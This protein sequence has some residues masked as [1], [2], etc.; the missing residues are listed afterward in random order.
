MTVR[1]LIT[2]SFKS[3]HIIGAGDELD[4]EEMT[5]AF[6]ELNGIVEQANIDKL[7]G[8]FET[9]INFPTIA[10]Q[11]SYTIGPASST[12]DVISTR[13]VE[14]M[15]GYSRRSTL[16]FPIQVRSKTDYDALNL[17]SMGAGGWVSFAYYQ[18]AWP[19][20]TIYLWPKPVDALTTIFFS[21]MAEVTAFATIDDTVS[22][23][24]GYRTWLQLK[25]AKRVAPGFG[26][27]FSDELKDNLMEVEASIKA[28]NIKP[29]PIARTGLTSLAGGSGGR[30][31]VLSDTSN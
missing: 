28:N 29:M 8:Y 30:Y 22:M 20:G 19:K 1:D 18:A 31:N 12:P 3:T 23:P 27:P 2:K 4:T 11:L 24:P 5:D 7:F 25:L 16:D 26:M 21:V 15:E 17:K 14:I 13:P 10:N 9:T 6:D